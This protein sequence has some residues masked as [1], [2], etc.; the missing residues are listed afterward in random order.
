[1][2]DLL[3]VYVY[4]QTRRLSRLGAGFQSGSNR[5]YRKALSER[6]EACDL[7]KEAQAHLWDPETVITDGARRDEPTK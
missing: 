7:E 1:M 6:V 2:C 3:T 5:G 4:L